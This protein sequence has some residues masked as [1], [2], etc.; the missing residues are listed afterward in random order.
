MRTAG[1]IMVGSATLPSVLVVGVGSLDSAGC[2][3][4]RKNIEELLYSGMFPI[5]GSKK[6]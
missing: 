4:K 5:V 1:I 6:Y 3:V 2:D